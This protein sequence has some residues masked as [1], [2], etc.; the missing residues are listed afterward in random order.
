MAAVV[1][2]WHDRP[3]QYNIHKA[4]RWRWKHQPLALPF[5]LGVQAV[6][7]VEVKVQEP[8][9]LLAVEVEVQAEV[10]A[11]EGFPLE[12]QTVEVQEPFARLDVEVEVEVVLLNVEVEVEVVARALAHETLSV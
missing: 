4:R 11:V 6:H 10:Q 12:L 8:F 1:L 2:P 7:V 9:A 3:H 5:A